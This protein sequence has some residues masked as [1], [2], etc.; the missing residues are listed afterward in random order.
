MK[1]LPRKEKFEMWWCRIGAGLF[2]ETRGILSV[3][4]AVLFLVRLRLFMDWCNLQGLLV[5][6]PR[7]LLVLRRFRDRKS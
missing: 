6:H 3:S 1:K 5:Q 4:S 2:I 7:A